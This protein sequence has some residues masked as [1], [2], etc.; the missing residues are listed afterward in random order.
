MSESPKKKSAFRALALYATPIPPLA[1]GTKALLNAFRG[2]AGAAS[3]LKK[4]K[5]ERAAPELTP[6]GAMSPAEKFH[7]ACVTDSWTEQDLY[8]QMAAYR[9]A[10]FVQLFVG[11]MLLPAAV[12]LVLYSPWWVIA[13]GVPALVSFSI[14]MLVQSLRHAWWQCQ[15]DMREM[16]SFKEFVGRSDLFGRLFA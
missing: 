16:I 11:V 2:I 10:K 8:R 15:I 14:V 13:F 12:L 4:E 3:Q 6:W 1:R 5:S 9:A 7:H